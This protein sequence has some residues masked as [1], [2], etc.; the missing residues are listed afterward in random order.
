MDTQL[1]HDKSWCAV[2]IGRTCANL[3]VESIAFDFVFSFDFVCSLC[4]ISWY[5][6]DMTR[7]NCFGF[8]VRTNLYIIPYPT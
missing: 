2:D 5:A 7:I 3:T 4:D 8:G 1:A 6:V